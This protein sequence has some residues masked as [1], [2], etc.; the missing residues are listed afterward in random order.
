MKYHIN[1]KWKLQV[2]NIILYLIKR[3]HTF[4]LK[5]DKNLEKIKEQH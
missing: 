2:Y 3:E 4:F 5:N 1:Y